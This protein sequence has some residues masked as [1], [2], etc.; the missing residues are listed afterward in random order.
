MGWG[1]RAGRADHG[2]TPNTRMRLCRARIHACGWVAARLSRGRIWWAPL[3]DGAGSRGR[4][5][6][7]LGV[8]GRAVV[9][10]RR[11]L[12]PTIA[13]FLRPGG[14]GASPDGAGS[15]RRSAIACT[16]P[17]RAGVGGRACRGAEPPPTDDCGFPSGWGGG[18]AS[19]DGAGSHRRCRVAP[20]WA[21]RRLGG[22]GR[23]V[24]AGRSPLLQ[25]MAAFLGPGGGGASPDGAG[26]HRRSRDRLHGAGPGGCWRA[27]GCRGA[28][29]PPTDEAYPRS[30]VGVAGGCRGAEPPPTDDARPIGLRRAGG[31]R[32]AEPPPTDAV[33][34]R[35]VAGAVA[36]AHGRLASRSGRW[37]A[38]GWGGW[39]TTWGR[40]Y[41]GL[42]G[43]GGGGH[44][45]WVVV[46]SWTAAI[47]SAT[48]ASVMAL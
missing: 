18:G 15:H 22:G 27:G 6:L 45:A 14:G 36:A 43:A 33:A 26:S 37:G 3:P 8:G 11:P 19:P 44:A 12:L 48:S 25:T 10:G 47:T 20:G 29:P 2:P 39:A 30:G 35:R 1:L 41:L 16:V 13:A 42:G 31:C 40:P 24:V 28:E 23:A 9:A 17:G 46:I 34:A 4:R 32:G 7:R 38:G 5:P 21:R